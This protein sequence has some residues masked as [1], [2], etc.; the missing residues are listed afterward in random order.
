MP[1][2]YIECPECHGNRFQENILSVIY[3][4]LNITQV[5]DAPIE[6]I[7]GLFKDNQVISNIIQCMIDI[8]MGYVSLGQMSMNL[9]GGEAQRIKLAKCLGAKSTGKNLYILDEP[10]SGLNAKDIGLL[11]NIL[12]RLSDENETILLIEHNVEFI[13]NVADYLIDLGTVAGDKGGTTILEGGPM[14]VMKNKNSSWYG[15]E[16]QLNVSK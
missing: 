7:I 1:D 14:D 15:F 9:S 8:G 5:L 10:T 16:K 4:G 12:L 13:A 2:S 6:N 3:N 11:K